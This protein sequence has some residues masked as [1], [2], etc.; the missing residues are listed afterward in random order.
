MEGNGNATILARMIDGKWMIVPSREETEALAAAYPY[1]TIPA[2]MRLKH[3]TDIDDAE[4]RQLILRVAAGA[5]GRDALF[6]LLDPEGDILE[7]FMPAEEPRRPTATTTEDAIDTFLSTYG[8]PS[9]RE[10][11]LLEKLIFNPVPDD[12]AALLEREEAEGLA[13][14]AEAA[15]APSAS[16]EQDRLLDAFLAGTGQQEKAAPAPQPAPQPAPKPANSPHHPAAPV[17]VATPAPDESLSMSLAQVYIRRGRYDKAYDII[18]ALSLGDS[19]KSVYFA[20]QLRFL[21]KLMLVE[22]A[23]TSPAGN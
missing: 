16:S 13:L 2:A 19:K 10:Q 21:Q 9:P 7:G 17:P 22:R 15:S 18:H 20:D 1:T 23:K 5:P 3:A 8:N 12:Y 14:A 4:R 11:A 6:R